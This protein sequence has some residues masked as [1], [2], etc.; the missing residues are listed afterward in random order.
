MPEVREC[1]AFHLAITSFFE[2][3]LET[4]E[5]LTI[6]DL[7][8]DA[9]DSI[10]KE[11]KLSQDRC[12][13]RLQND[14]TAMRGHASGQEALYPEPL[15]TREAW[16]TVR[17]RKS[18]KAKEI[19]PDHYPT[20]PP[21]IQSYSLIS[22]ATTMRALILG[23]RQTK[24]ENG[25]TL[26]LKLSYLTHTCLQIYTAEQ[27]EIM[28]Q[29][30]KPSE[31]D[32]RRARVGLGIE[33]AAHTI[34][35]ISLDNLFEPLWRDTFE[36]LPRVYKNIYDGYSD[37]LELVV[38]WLEEVEQKGQKGRALWEKTARSAIRDSEGQMPFCGVGVYTV[39]ELF[40]D[41]GF[42]PFMSLAELVHCPSRMARFCEALWSYV[43]KSY[44]DLQNLLAGRFVPSPFFRCLVIPN[45]R[46]LWAFFELSSNLRRRGLGQDVTKPPRR[47]NRPLH[48]S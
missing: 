10:K 27:W 42:W 44:S 1:I 35:F 5:D 48:F 28:V 6:L 4:G 7:W 31:N 40:H 17:S 32:H 39:C 41:A 23:F 15:L 26:Y 2:T 25:R 22:V 19:A 18:K 30:P 38:E 45:K 8:A 20:P 9:A 11:T 37:W 33:M 3:A 43:H 34:A 29:T 16:R 21:P 13:Y 24:E 46:L 36:A 14:S 47:S 12:P